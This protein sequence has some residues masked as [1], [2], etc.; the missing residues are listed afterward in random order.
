[1]SQYPSSVL[2]V[3]EAARRLGCSPQT[4]R[5]HLLAGRLAGRKI[6]REWVVLWPATTAAARV[7][8][9]RAREPRAAAPIPATA[10]RQ[11]LREVGA[12]LIEVGNHLAQGKRGRGKLFLTWRTP[13]ALRVTVAMGRTSPTKGWSP[14]ALGLDI[15]FW[16]EERPRWRR[17][18][19]FL[20]GYER[21]RTW[22][23]PQL[24]RID[25][26][27]D[28][29]LVELRRLEAA[30]LALEEAMPPRHHGPKQGATDYGTHTE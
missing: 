24:L 19:P 4:V 13:H 18:M 29:V 23:A 22:C 14:H 11:R 27:G 3:E 9:R 10:I 28:V 8:R 5:R 17:V 20:R 25:G 1:M 16:V 12:K 15:P 21:I 6:R 2:S 26:V 30:L 7:P